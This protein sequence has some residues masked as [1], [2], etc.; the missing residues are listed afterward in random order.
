VHHGSSC[1]IAAPTDEIGGNESKIRKKNQ[2]YGLFQ[3]IFPIFHFWR[4]K[5]NDPGKK[6]KIFSVIFG[7]NV[8]KS[9]R[10]NKLLSVFVGPLVIVTMQ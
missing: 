10:L 9:N 3:C 4:Q 2:N 7:V 8:L 5:K 6:I 1:E